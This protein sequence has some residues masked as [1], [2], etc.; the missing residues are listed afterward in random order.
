[1][2]DSEEVITFPC[3]FTLKIIGKKTRE[4]EQAVVCI[5]HKHFPKL[6]EGAISL[7]SSKGGKYLSISATVP[8][9]NKKQLDNL[10]EELTNNDQI[11]FAL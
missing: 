11:L 4:F 8:A 10:Y 7:K 3:N 6:G 5:I 1:M 2:R 9:Q